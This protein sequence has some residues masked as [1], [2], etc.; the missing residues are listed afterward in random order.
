MINKFPR[1]KYFIG[2]SFLFKKL[3]TLLLTKNK[4]DSYGSQT[5]TLLSSLTNR[6]HTL[7]FSSY[8]MGVYFYLKSLKLPRG[9]EVLL[10]PITIPDLV[11]VILNLDLVPVF[12]DMDLEN[13]SLCINSL[14]KNI[15]NKSKVLIITPLSGCYSKGED[16]V[17]YAKE[18]ELFVIEDISQVYGIPHLH[19]SSDV[20]IGSLS[21]G[22]ALTSFTGGFLS[23]NQISS[24]QNIK[25]DKEYKSLL[26]P[27]KIRFLFELFDNFK[28]LL[29][30]NSLI[31]N[32]FTFNILKLILSI[33]PN[34]FKKIHETKFLTRS[35]DKDVFFDDLPILRKSLPKSWFT[36]FSK[37]QSGVLLS[38]CHQLTRI[39]KRRIELSKLLFE[40]L[41]SNVIE[42]IPKGFHDF[43]TNCYYHLPIYT[44]Q[45]SSADISSLMFHAGLDNDGYGLNL[46]TEEEV[47]KEFH[48]KTPHAFRIKKNCVFIPLHES[49]SNSEVIT[50]AQ[51]LNYIFDK[52]P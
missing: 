14:D 7:F 51:K 44:D 41:H 9:T 6:D 34:F 46:C 20:M 11:N 19:S 48:S 26:P 3:F 32:Y 16:I 30:T 2:F 1:F 52:E 4:N 21:S 42:H 5:Q 10:T 28:I 29:A 37:W 31:F 35:P 40:H 36:Y 49:Y 39:S 18:K 8:R 17:S 45:I 27:P 23:T 50:I 15:S 43:E 25:N 47:F 38:C 12:C 33:R 22:K 24:Y 13:H